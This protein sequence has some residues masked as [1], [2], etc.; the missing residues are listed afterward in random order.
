PDKFIPL[1]EETGLILP[2]G[3]QVL[4]R[5]CQQAKAWQNQGRELRVAV[6]LSGK[7]VILEDLFTTLKELLEQ[8]GVSPHLLEL[9]ITEGFVISHAEEG[10]RSLGKMHELGVYLAIDD[11][12][13]GYSSLSYLKRLPVDRLKIDQSFV[14]GL[15]DERDDTAIVGT[16]IAMAEN[17][18]LSV[19]AEGV[20]TRQQADYLTAHGCHEL[21]GYLFSPPIEAEEV[22]KWC[23]N[24]HKPSGLD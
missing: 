18:G 14:Q 22:E 2:L 16:I 23:D 8:T 15:P 7:Q 19:I 6:N 12:G 20:E 21:Q 13:T 17:L 1:A 3:R 9:E 4:E 11:F 5:A 24:H 10:I